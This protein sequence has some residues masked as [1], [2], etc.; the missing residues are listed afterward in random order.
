MPFIAHPTAPRP[1]RFGLRPLLAVLQGRLV[2]PLTSR[3]Q[4]WGVLTFACMTR[5]LTLGAYPL[6]DTTEARYGEI[7]RK[8]LETGQWLVPQIDYGVPFWGKPPLSFW[9]TAMSYKLFGITE[10][11]ARL[12]SLLLGIA[13]CALVYMVGSRRHGVDHGLRASVVVAIRPC[14][15]APRCRWSGSGWR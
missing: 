5:L 3:Q 13:V 8:M 9:L 15:S 14:C 1:E 7:A 11:A 10:F 12:P 6:T 4:L 2:R